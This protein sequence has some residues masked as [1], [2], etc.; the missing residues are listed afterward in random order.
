[1][2]RVFTFALCLF[3]FFF[4]ASLASAAV[5]F[6]AV[7]DASGSATSFSFSHTTANQPN[8]VAVA[9]IATNDTGITFSNV[10][11]NAVAMTELHCEINGNGVN[12]CLYRLTAPATGANNFTGDLSGTGEFAAAIL[13]FHGVDQTTPLDATSAQGSGGAA[14]ESTLVMS[15]ATNDMVVDCIDVRSSTFTVTT[16]GG[17]TQRSNELEGANVQ[18]ITSTEAG[19]ASV[20]MSHDWSGDGFMYYGHIS[21]NINQTAAALS[22]G[23]LRRRH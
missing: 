10:A 15:S 7:T 13:T 8:R 6:D 14:L 4:W 5:T 12:I 16:G 2:S 3:T 21:A 1:M 17:Q 18:L 19:A 22:F 11:Y 20:T 9:C 23:P